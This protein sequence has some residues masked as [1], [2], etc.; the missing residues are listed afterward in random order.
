MSLKEQLNETG[1]Y[2]SIAVQMIAIILAGV[3]GG[4]FLDKFLD[5]RFI[6]TVILSFSSV[7][8]A[9]YFV[10]KDLIKKK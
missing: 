7:I 6:F 5:T 4:K 10:V 2:T 3:F 9:I 8:L 1:K